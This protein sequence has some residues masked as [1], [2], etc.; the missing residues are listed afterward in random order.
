[1]GRLRCAPRA[2]PAK[3]KI[4]EGQC[5]GAGRVAC[6]W[7]YQGPPLLAFGIG[8]LSSLLGIGG[9]E[10]MGPLLLSLNVLP[11]VSA[12]ST[13]MMSLLNSS[14]NIVHYA[15]IG[16]IDIEW[17][18]ITFFIGVVG[19]ITGRMWALYMTKTFGRISVM[20]FCLATVLFISFWLLVFHLA[21][22]NP[23]F[24]IFTQYCKK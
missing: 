12:A 13:S 15:I 19:G 21:T 6:E 24:S 2:R 20:V 23:N 10:L 8:I 14:S 11:Q 22:E 7:A 5:R 16:E 4:R 9:G 1:L 17:F 18:F 3:R